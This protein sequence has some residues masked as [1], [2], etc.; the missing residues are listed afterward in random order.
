MDETATHYLFVAVDTYAHIKRNFLGFKNRKGK[1]EERICA[2]S[3]SGLEGNVLAV[4]NLYS[5]SIKGAKIKDDPGYNS[6]PIDPAYYGHPR[7]KDK[8]YEQMEQIRKSTVDSR[9]IVGSDSLEVFSDFLQDNGGILDDHRYKVR[10]FEEMMLFWVG[11]IPSEYF[12]AH[13][14][15]GLIEDHITLESDSEGKY[16]EIPRDTKMLLIKSHVRYP[17]FLQSDRALTRS[18]KMTEA[19]NLINSVL[20]KYTKQ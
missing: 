16:P 3:M 4:D 1:I 15:S 6:R 2:I 10:S 17:K 20:S 18:I 19:Y 14:N 7:R 13:M 5:A 12:A 8:I 9:Y 11:R